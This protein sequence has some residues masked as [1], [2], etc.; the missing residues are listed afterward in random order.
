MKKI[1]TVPVLLCFLA[2]GPAHAK[3]WG[4]LNGDGKINIFDLIAF[5]RHLSGEETLP[6]MGEEIGLLEVGIPSPSLGGDG[7]N[8]KVTRDNVGEVHA[9]LMDAVFNIYL[10]AKAPLAEGVSG[11]V[12]G[13][14][15]GYADV[16][17]SFTAGQRA[18]GGAPGVID[19]TAVF[20]DYSDDGRL[21]I[22]GKIHYGGISLSSVD[23]HPPLYILGTLNYAGS[24][25]GRNDYR[26]T[27]QS[28]HGQL[29]YYGSYSASRNFSG[30]SSFG[31]T[32]PPPED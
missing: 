32:W 15:A 10:K 21:Y 19:L 29:S 26:F 13:D 27:I 3:V 22:S 9:L 4:D 31:D 18:N 30:T 8:V 1:L 11:R 5:L 20:Y 24:Y 17:G 2:A 25:K 14:I 12:N 7:D 16:A 23:E 6:E 28:F